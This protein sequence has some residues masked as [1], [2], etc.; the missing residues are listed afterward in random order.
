MRVLSAIVFVGS[1][2]WGCAMFL[3]QW[4]NDTLTAMETL[5]ATPDALRAMPAVLVPS[6]IVGSLLAW[7]YLERKPK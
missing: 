5:K 4:D 6:L 3:Y 2:V 7:R 1:A